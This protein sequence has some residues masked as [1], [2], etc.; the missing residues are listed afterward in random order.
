MALEEL[1]SERGS[2][3]F[4][5]GRL[6]RY[7]LERFLAKEGITL[8]FGMLNPSDATH[9]DDDSTI[10]RCIGY[11]L[12]DDIKARRMIV[13]NMFG[14][15]SKNPKDLLTAQDPI[16]PEN[17]S[18]IRK[19]LTEADLII[20]AWGA[21][22]KKLRI[23]SWQSRRLIQEAGPKLR[24]LGTNKDGSPKHPLYLKET[25]PLLEWSGN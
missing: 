15:V 13:V 23:K 12:R 11:A 18:F 22:H 2:A 6:H 21:M 17:E 14:F 10:T 9:E 20:C 3:V 5:E 7:W 19:A 16:G 8:A 25:A 24:C 4:S 1:S